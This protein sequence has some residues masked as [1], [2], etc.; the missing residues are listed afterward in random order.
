MPVFGKVEFK[1]APGKPAVL[2]QDNV[3]ILYSKEIEEYPKRITEC[4]IAVPFDNRIFFAGNP[5]YPNAIFHSSLENPAYCSD[6]DYYED[7]TTSMVKSLVVGNNV[8]WVL[9]ESN[10]NRDTI[11]YHTPTTDSSYGRIYPRSQGNIAK[12]CYGMGYNF[13][14]T[15]V[16][17]SREGLEGIS[18][19][20]FEFAGFKP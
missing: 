9:K 13:R 2:G 10:Q 5:D 8:L 17:L 6:L 16:F 18:R 4:T 7:G 1:K 14:D 3:E 11:F 12:G 19:K 15:I 20:C